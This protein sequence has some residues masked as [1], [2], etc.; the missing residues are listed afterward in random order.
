MVHG[1]NRVVTIIKDRP[2]LTLW[3]GS[4]PTGKMGSSTISKTWGWQGPISAQ[5]PSQAKNRRQGPPLPNYCNQGQINYQGPDPSQRYG[6]KRNQ[7]GS[8]CQYE[9]GR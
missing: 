3:T 7:Y 1:D 8:V 4:I 9:G 5:D 2:P 6:Q